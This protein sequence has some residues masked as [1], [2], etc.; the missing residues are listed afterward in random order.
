M[1]TGAPI[2]DC[3][4]T[5]TLVAGVF[6]LVTAMAAAGAAVAGAE[7]VDAVIVA[8]IS[9]RAH[10]AA[11]GLSTRRHPQLNNTV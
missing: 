5:R 3:L 8:N 11:T 4:M 1:G 6:L 7:L 2:G 10:R 9:L